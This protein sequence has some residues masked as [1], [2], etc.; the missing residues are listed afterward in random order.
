VVGGEL[1]KQNA[2]SG[3]PQRALVFAR[4][5]HIEALRAFRHNPFSF[6]AVIILS[7]GAQTSVL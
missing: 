7:N 1:I 6:G 2:R 4:M 5:M 3:F